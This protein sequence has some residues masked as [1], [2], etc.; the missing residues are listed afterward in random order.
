MSLSQRWNGIWDEIINKCKSFEELSDT[1]IK[2]ARYSNITS[3]SDSRYI[4]AIQ[5]TGLT[6]GDFVNSFDLDISSGEGN[7]KGS[8]Y[9]DSQNR[10]DQLLSESD[11]FMYSGTDRMF[12]ILFQKS[13]EVPQDGILWIAFQ[14]E[15][16][17]FDIKHSTIS[18]VF[19]SFDSNRYYGSGAPNPFSGGGYNTQP[20]FAIL[21]TN[22][23]VIKHHGVNGSQPDEFFC[24]V[25]ANNMT[26]APAS[27]RGTNNTFTF[28]IDINRRS[29][30]FAEGASKVIDL[31]SEI[32]DS[33]HMTNL[34][35][36]VHNCTA[37]IAIDEIA[38][39]DNLYLTGARITVSCET[40]VFIP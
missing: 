40:Q 31:A 34:N 25:S 26:T 18:P 17:N 13:V 38:E 35:D 14:N 9:G 6:P 24:I 39:A 28:N 1:A 11:E 10:P 22:P 16:G 8:I 27:T 30:D 37:E 21:H 19:L 3:H 2:S 4:K 15:N 23:K 5:F 12:N 20:F 7:I 33:I 36:L 29:S 32:Y